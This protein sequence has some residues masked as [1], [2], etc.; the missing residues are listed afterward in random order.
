VELLPDW[1]EEWVAATR[2]RYRLARLAA[3]ESAACALLE[4]KQLGSALITAGAVVQ[5]EPLRES[6]RRIVMRVHLAQGNTVEAI[7][8]HQRYRRLLRSEFG[9]E[10]C[11]EMDALVA[12]CYRQ[13]VTPG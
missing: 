8:E 7:R 2:E 5:A 13:H 3:L 4:R 6:A 12:D 11:A 10:P 9:V 1:D